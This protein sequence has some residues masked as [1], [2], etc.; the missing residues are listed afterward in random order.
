MILQDSRSR[1]FQLLAD[2]VRWRL[3]RLLLAQPL[4]VAEATRIVGVAQSGVSRHLGLLKNA[5]LVHES[6]QGGW[7]WYALAPT[8]PRGVAGLWAGLREELEASTD[9]LGDDARLA[10]VLRERAE[11]GEDAALPGSEPGRSW[12]AWAHALAGLVPRQRVVHLGAGTGALSREVARF[13]A[14]LLAV[15]P[16][17]AQAVEARQRLEALPQASVVCAPLTQVPRADASFDLA[18]IVQALAAALEPQAVLAEAR[19]LLAP[20]GRLLWLDLLPHQET[21]VEERLGHRRRGLEP[22]VAR[23][24]LDALGLEDVRVEAAER[25]R[26]NPFVVLIASGRA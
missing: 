4:R 16:D 19:R 23:G 14:P 25:R 15:E 21:W 17:A 13:A 10:E 2:P 7:A 5:G 11:A 22:Q 8:P 3:L 12:A 26:G 1:V 24:W 9:L 20:G 6:R 18:L